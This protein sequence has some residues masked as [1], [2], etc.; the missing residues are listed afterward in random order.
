MHHIVFAATANT[1]LQRSLVW[2]WIIPLRFGSQQVINQQEGTRRNN[3]E[4]GS[5]LCSVDGIVLTPPNRGFF[6]PV[7]RQPLHSFSKAFW[8]F[9]TWA[10]VDLGRASESFTDVDQ[11][12]RAAA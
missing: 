10:G 11:H 6:T 3:V 1:V 5:I 4:P 12:A 7:G 8:P 9:L 2:A